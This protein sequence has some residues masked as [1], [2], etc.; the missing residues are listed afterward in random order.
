M[1]NAFIRE[2]REIGY[3]TQEELQLGPEYIA[4]KV[5]ELYQMMDKD[6]EYKRTE[7]KAISLYNE[8][9]ELVKDNPRAIELLMMFDSAKTEMETFTSDFCYKKGL[10][11]KKANVGYLTPETEGIILV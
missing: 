1:E 10:E 7:L 4:N 8:L 2:E 11:A 6:E 3:N 9:Q 5:D